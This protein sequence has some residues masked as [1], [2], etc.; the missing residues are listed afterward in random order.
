M[1]YAG[2]ASRGKRAPDIRVVQTRPTERGTSRQAPRPRAP[3]QIP[4]AGRS[5]V[6]AAGV[7]LGMAMGA[8]VA[9]LLAPQTGADTRRYL[10]RRALRMG[11][12]SRDAWD[13][14]RVE[15]LMAAKRRKRATALAAVDAV[16]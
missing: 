13:D 5:V 12:R 3:S 2:P 6:F 10:A 16:T 1:S 7:F 11:R 15:L 14:L 8:G 4:A 9:L